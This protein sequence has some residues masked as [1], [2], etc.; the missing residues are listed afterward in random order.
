MRPLEIRGCC[1]GDL[2]G[3][4]IPARRQ[5]WGHFYLFRCRRVYMGKFSIVGQE[6]SR[7]KD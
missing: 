6:D 1:G 5:S 2:E 3:A 4:I 7:R